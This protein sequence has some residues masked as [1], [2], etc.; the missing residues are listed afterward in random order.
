MYENPTLSDELDSLNNNMFP[1]AALGYFGIHNISSQ[2]SYLGLC[3]NWP[4]FQQKMSCH[5]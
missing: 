1:G 5:M 2:W 4:A 3:M